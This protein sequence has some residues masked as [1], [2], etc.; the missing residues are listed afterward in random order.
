[1]SATYNKPVAKAVL[2]ALARRRVDFV[3]IGDSNQLHG[4]NGWDDGFQYALLNCS[5]PSPMYASGLLSQNEGQGIGAGVG[6]AANGGF[7]AGAFSGAPAPLDQFMNPGTGTLAPGN[8]SYI[9]SGPSGGSQ[10][11]LTHGLG[12]DVTAPLIYSLWY[13]TFPGGAGSFQAGARNNVTFAIIG[14]AGSQSTNAGAYGMRRLDFQIPA[15]S[16]PSAQDIQFGVSMTG[17]ASVAGPYFGTW[18]RVLNPNVLAGFSYHTLYGVGGQPLRVMAS[19][20]QGANPAFL[21][22]FFSIIRE[23]QQQSPRM[24]VVIINAG[25]NDRNDASNTS[26]GPQAVM[27]GDSAGAFYDNGRAAIL[28]IRNIWKINGWPLNELYFWILPSQPQSA[29]DDT[30]IVSYRTASQRLCDSFPRAWTTDLNVLYTYTQG[31]TNGYFFGPPSDTHLT[32]LGYE[33]WALASVN[34]ALS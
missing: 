8:Y 22:H 1:M 15:N 34:D 19:A 10:V 29:P 7:Y 18:M 27:T 2:Q 26:V 16:V 4:G 12:L 17:G 11:F 33:Q 30:K 21:T 9:A 28:A 25:M 20:L 14:Y 13:G 3:G 5:S 31:V 32:Q 23:Q 24:I 6:Y